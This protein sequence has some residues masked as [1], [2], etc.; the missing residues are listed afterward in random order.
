MTESLGQKELRSMCKDRGIPA[1]RKNTDMVDAIKEYDARNT[2]KEETTNTDPIVVYTDG[3][4]LGNPGRGGWGVII[5]WKDG[6]TQL[7]GSSPQSTNNEMELTAAFNA[8]QELAKNEVK[9]GI[10]YTDSQYVQKGI[11]IW[12]NKWRKNS[13]QSATNKPI[14]NKEIWRLLD[15]EQAKIDHI[16]WRYVKAHNGDIMN[17]R[18]DKIAREAAE[19]Q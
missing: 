13:Y 12:M 14:K 9:N 19:K 7:W 17:E 6:E 8:C 16:D 5:Q 3:S 11:T 1:K 4:C 15:E 10:I 18:V 2:E